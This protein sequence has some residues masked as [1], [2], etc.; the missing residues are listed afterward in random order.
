[1][2][3]QKRLSP[4]FQEAHVL[5]S[6]LG[7][8]DNV[9][10]GCPWHIGITQLLFIETLS[11]SFLS[12]KIFLRARRKKQSRKQTISANDS[13]ILHIT[14]LLKGLLILY[15]FIYES[16]LMPIHR[17]KEQ[18]NYYKDGGI[19]E[20]NPG[21]GTTTLCSFVWTPAEESGIAIAK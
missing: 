13:S 6:V 4:N 5:R 19:R 9:C 18:F 1:M 11:Q 16:L 7:L 17:E 15:L 21:S 12:R 20:R 3:S 8:R 14:F 10:S 2:N